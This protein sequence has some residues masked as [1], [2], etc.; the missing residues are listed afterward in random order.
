MTFLTKTNQLFI[1]C[2]FKSAPKGYYQIMNILAKPQDYNHVIPVFL[3][4]MSNKSFYS[5]INIFSDIKLNL[6]IK[7]L[8]INWNSIYFIHDFEKGLVKAIEEYFPESKSIGCFYH[9]CKSLWV[10]A[11]KH[12]CFKKKYSKEILFILFAYKIYPFIIIKEEYIKH[13]EMMINNTEEKNTFLRLHNFFVKNWSKQR[14]LNYNEYLDNKFYDTTNNFSEAFNHALNKLIN[15]NHPKI[16]ILVEKMNSYIALR[17]NEYYEYIKENNNKDI[18][19]ID[20]K[21]F[22]FTKIKNF[23]EKYQLLYENEVNL[24]QIKVLYEKNKIEIYEILIFLWIDIINDEE[25]EELMKIFYNINEK[26][27]KETVSEKINIDK[28][29]KKKR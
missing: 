27:K 5:Y 16:S 19:D 25:D 21:E 12:Q 6:L 9:Y 15:I 2:T 4:L 29:D 24:E 23:I 11:K 26:I 18:L 14:L 8:N 7:K 13:I 17:I 28:S 10:Y 20:Q 22:I 1:D 3:V